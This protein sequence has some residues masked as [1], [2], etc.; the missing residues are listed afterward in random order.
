MLYQYQLQVIQ[1][2]LVVVVQSHQEIHLI[3]LDQIQVFQQS[4]LLVVV[5]EVVLKLVYQQHQILV[6]QE[7]QEEEVLLHFLHLED[8][9]EEQ[10][11]H[12]QLVPL[13]GMLVVVDITKVACILLLEGVA[14]QQQLEVLV[15]MVL[16]QHL[17]EMVE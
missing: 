3:E 4:H 9:Q 2:Q 15:E 12:L 5:E 13:K 1:L 11:I 7:D 16:I 10:E 14:V 6:D 8:F 17:Q